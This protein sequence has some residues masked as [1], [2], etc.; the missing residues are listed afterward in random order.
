LLYLKATELPPSSTAWVHG[1]SSSHPGVVN[2]LLGDGSVRSV[3]DGLDAALY[4][5]LITRAG[6]EP[7]NDFHNN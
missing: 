2:H 3:S 5:H 6:G 7:V 1:P 4:M